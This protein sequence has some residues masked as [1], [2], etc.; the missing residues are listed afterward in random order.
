MLII[1]GSG[2]SASLQYLDTSALELLDEFRIGGLVGDQ[3]TQSGD[4]REEKSGFLAEFGMVC[5]EDNVLGICDDAFLEGGL[6]G[7]ALAGP[8]IEME[9]IS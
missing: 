7:V 4:V 1:S 6:T 9:S 2:D 8:A 3:A 5:E